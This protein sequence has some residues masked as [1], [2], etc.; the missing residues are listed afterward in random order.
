ML[1]SL[2]H[3]HDV[4]PPRGRKHS[5]GGRIDSQG[6][7]ERAS[8]F[9]AMVFRQFVATFPWA[10]LLTQN[11]SYSCCSGGLQSAH[12]NRPA[13]AMDTDD[14]MTSDM[15]A[16]L[17]CLPFEKQAE[18]MREA[19]SDTLKHLSTWRLREIHRRIEAELDDSIPAVRATL[20]IIEG[21]LALRE[22]AEG[23]YWR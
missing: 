14:Q 11:Q 4:K 7:R 13:A 10:I 16:A 23:S 9:Q 12:S 2:T 22:I 20:E 1:R 5:A 17:A 21:Q 18:G 8:G 19:V 6:G 15:L 3:C